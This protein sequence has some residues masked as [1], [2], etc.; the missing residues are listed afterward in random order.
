MPISDTA[1][2]VKRAYRWSEFRRR[3]AYC[4]YAPNLYHGRAGRP[5][6]DLNLRYAAARRIVES[7]PGRHRSH[8]GTDEQTALLLF[9][10]EQLRP[11]FA[12]LAEQ[13]RRDTQHL[14]LISKKV[15]HPAYFRIMGMGED[16]VP[17]L[18]E[19]LRDNPAHW[20][21]ALRATAKTD[22]SP[23]QAN[24]SMAREAWLDWGRS[25]GLIK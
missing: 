18:L 7:L 1:N 21:A 10:A 12:T 16:A 13:W 5:N 14:S 15:L 17:L 4:G 8:S 24:P 6:E 2:C 22:P 3:T 19:T 9:R 23:P 20:F 25:R 11:E